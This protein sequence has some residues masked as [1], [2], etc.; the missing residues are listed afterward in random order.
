MKSKTEASIA[1]SFLIGGAEYVKGLIPNSR[2]FSV[3]THSQAFGATAGFEEFIQF[4]RVRLI[5][6]SLQVRGKALAAR[7]QHDLLSHH[8]RIAAEPFGL[9]FRNSQ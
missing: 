3:Q 8:H 6:P 1:S 2:L 5:A 9:V 4:G 7:V